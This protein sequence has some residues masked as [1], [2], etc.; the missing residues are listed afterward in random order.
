MY[1]LLFFYNSG[2]NF[3]VISMLVDLLLDTIQLFSFVFIVTIERSLYILPPFFP[4]TYSPLQHSVL[5]S[6]FAFA[7][8]NEILYEIM[9]V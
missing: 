6:A 1:L 3:Q 7:L 8:L 5:A 9:H 4:P 2:V